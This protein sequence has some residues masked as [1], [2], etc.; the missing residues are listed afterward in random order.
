MEQ[1]TL[2][3]HLQSDFQAFENGLNGNAVKPIHQIRKSAFD[4]FSKL[5]FPTIRHEEWKYSNVKS[6][7]E[8]AYNFNA[9]SDFSKKDLDQLPIPNL[10]GNILYFINCVI[11]V[12]YLIICC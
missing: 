5:N 10:T 8:K 2:N 3:K 12:R 7:T 11:T 1:N 9:K 6:I 4:T